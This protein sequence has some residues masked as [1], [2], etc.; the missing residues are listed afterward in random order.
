MTP[1]GDI[2]DDAVLMT[3][4]TVD[5]DVDVDLD[6]ELLV[7]ATTQ[8]PPPAVDAEVSGTSP[9]LY[10]IIVAGLKTKNR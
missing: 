10:K 4:T 5:V 9:L 3:V 2:V 6:D 7:D 1:L 8:P